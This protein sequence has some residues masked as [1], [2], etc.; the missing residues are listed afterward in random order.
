MR[1][2]VK[3]D[4]VEFA[5]VDAVVAPQIAARRPHLIKER[6]QSPCLGQFRCGVELLFVT[7]GKSGAPESMNTGKPPKLLREEFARNQITVCW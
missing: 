4:V 3:P 6:S 2:A 1:P 5:L 7:E